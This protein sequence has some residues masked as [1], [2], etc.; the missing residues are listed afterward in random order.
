MDM[1]NKD[2][3]NAIRHFVLICPLF[4]NLVDN[5]SP[6]K[7]NE[8]LTH[9]PICSQCSMFIKVMTSIEVNNTL[10]KSKMVEYDKDYLYSQIG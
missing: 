2:F 9:T 5:S 8:L 10:Y 6:E 1:T 4:E 3:T 7:M